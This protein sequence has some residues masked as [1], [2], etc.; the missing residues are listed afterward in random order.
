M[1]YRMND[2][3]TDAH[4]DQLVADVVS[5]TEGLTTNA[6]LVREII[7][8]ALKV[9]KDG[10]DRGDVRMMNT[11]MKEL[12]YSSLV[13]QPFGET[14]KIAVYGSARTDPEDPNYAMAEELGRRMAEDHGYLVI[15]GAGPGIM[16]AANKGAGKENS[17]GVNIRLPFEN[18][19]NEYLAPGKVINFKYFFTRK[20]QFVKESDA[21]ALL[22]G[23]FGTLD[24]AFELL[25]LVQTGKS[26][27]HPIVMVE[28]EGTGYW[29]AWEMMCDTLVSQGMISL[30][31][32]NLYKITTDVDEAVEEIVR[33]YR[34][35]HSQRFV[36]DLLVL[37]L[38]NKVSETLLGELSV[39]FAD[40]IRSGHIE[41]I[42]PTQAEVETDDHVELPRIAFDFDRHGYG[43]LR[44]LID[45][46]ND[47]AE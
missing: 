18:G 4:I 17:F 38:T 28:A 29:D 42:P 44:A 26:D 24:E 6:D 37:R 30:P 10:T 47:F 43:R 22:P 8:S 19:A 15:T 35:Y 21:F 3:E 20:V 31:D 45:R 14:R 36:D 41:S 33:F 11:A 2:P 9:I 39:E 1:H 40:I 25:T 7:V 12:R 32:L 46:L 16:E 23:G 34:V 27:L 13:F 5:E